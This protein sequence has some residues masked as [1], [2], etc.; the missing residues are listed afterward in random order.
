MFGKKQ[1]DN[2]EKACPFSFSIA[3]QNRATNPH[4]KCIKEACQMWDPQ[5]NDCGLKEK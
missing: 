2:K 5:R 4:I 1:E 3:V